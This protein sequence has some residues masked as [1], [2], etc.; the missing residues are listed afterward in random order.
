MSYIMYKI[1]IP[2]L[3][4]FI[5]KETDNCRNWP[6]LVTSGEW[7]LYGKQGDMYQSNW[8]LIRVNLVAA[9]GLLPQT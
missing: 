6:R 3:Y 5:F 9:F 2:R 1:G 4:F 8:W 7:M